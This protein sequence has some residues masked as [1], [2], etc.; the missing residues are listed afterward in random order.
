M[1]FLLLNNSR[2]LLFF[3]LL[4]LER[5]I[6]MAGCCCICS[7]YLAC[8]LIHSAPMLRSTSSASCS[9]MHRAPVQHRV[10]LLYL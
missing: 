2:L 5:I 7:N 1:N 10:F 9:S 6:I 8:A 3:V 4:L